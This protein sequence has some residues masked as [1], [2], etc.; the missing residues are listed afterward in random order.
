[1]DTGR[2]AG[3]DAPMDTVRRIDIGVFAHDEED[4]IAAL[5][6]TLAR[7]DLFARPDLS[8]R[9]VVCANGC[10]DRTVER[11]RGA[12]AAASRGGG[13]WEVLDLAEGGKSRTWN[14]FVHEASR[15]D[16]DLLVL[17]DADIEIPDPGTLSR[18]ARFVESRP[19]V[20][21]TSSRPVKDIVHAPRDLTLRDRIIARAGGTLNDWRQS[22]CGQLYAVR[23]STAR[24][25]HL[26]VGLPVEDGFV[27]A[28]I[29]TDVFRASED[30][31]RID[32]DDRVFHVYR[33]E[34]GIR[35]L[36]RH[37]VRIVIGSAVNSAVF[38]RL[39]ATPDP[40][41]L[42][43]RAAAEP[44]WLAGFLRE[45]LPRRY[46]WVPPHF[47]FWRLGG[48]RSATPRRRPILLLGWGFDAVVYVLAQAAMARGRGAGHW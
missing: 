16:A 24:G 26:P 12:V 40:P 31:S 36:L 6:A 11:A 25:F 5:L 37:Q 14:R 22:I 28:M 4:S 34:R 41:G 10:T 9:V 18:L 46:G 44:G 45:A 32:G 30:L 29:L 7:Q 27:R 1:M 3:D 23:A 43:R 20:L 48:F 21:A 38:R 2:G 8:V 39:A 13:T 33:S 47:L 15:P 35:A 17:C 42:L 19:E